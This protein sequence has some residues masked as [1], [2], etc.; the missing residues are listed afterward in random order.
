MILRLVYNK[1]WK[2]ALKYPFINGGA[3]V[4]HPCMKV[5]AAMHVRCRAMVTYLLA[6][7]FAAACGIGEGLHSIPGCGHAVELPGGLF[8]LGLVKPAPTDS[9]GYGELGVLRQQGQPPLILDEAECAI[10]TNGA[11]GQTPTKAVDFEIRLPLVEHLP[12][13]VTPTLS[14]CVPKSFDARGPPVC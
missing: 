3:V 11:Q 5:F 8:Y 6:G 7:V 13:I 1:L 9:I 12:A 4:L 14:A 2:E 10:C